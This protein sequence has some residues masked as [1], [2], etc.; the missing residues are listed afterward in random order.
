MHEIEPRLW[1]NGE[2]GVARAD[3]VEV[4]L[5]ESPLHARLLQLDFA[6][7]LDTAELQEQGSARRDMYPAEIVAALALLAAVSR[8]ARAALG[9]TP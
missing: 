8:A 4:R 9:G 5:R 7:A 6:P 1:W 2:R 3:G